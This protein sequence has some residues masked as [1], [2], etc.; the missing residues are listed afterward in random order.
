VVTDPAAPPV[1]AGGAAYFS[2]QIVIVLRCPVVLPDSGKPA[3]GGE[4]KN[5][6]FHLEAG[7]A[8]RR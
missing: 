7:L 1:T 8:T 3:F 5:P 6:A 2:S 4:T